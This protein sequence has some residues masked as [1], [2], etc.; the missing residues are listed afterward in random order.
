M[1]FRCDLVPQYKRYK[2]KIDKAINR[3]FLSGRYIL[4]QEVSRFEQAFARYIGVKYAAGVAN[5]TEGLI[6][7]LMAAGIGRGDEVI[8]TPFTAIPT[9][10][11]IIHSGARPVFV[12]ICSDTFLIDLNKL[13]Q[14]IT[15]KTKAIIPVHLFGNVV[16]VSKLKKLIG[17]KITVIEDASQS[18]GSKIDRLQSGSLGDLGVFSFYPTKNLGA[19]GDGGMVVSK[20]KRLIDKIKL[21]RMYGMTDK[22]HIIVHGINSRLD[23]LQAAILMVKLKYLDSMNRKR[24]IIAQRYIRKLNPALF[25]HQYIPDNVYTNYHAFASRFRGNRKRFIEYLDRNG[26]QTN[27]YYPIPLHLQKANKFLG[28]KKGSFPVAERLCKEV[29][30]LPMYPE[31]KEKTQDYIIDR[32][33]KFKEVGL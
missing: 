7:S 8:T 6:L 31:L 15:L 21:L 10:S 11:A 20:N 13:A 23:E 12:D 18:H 9:V 16:G 3:V 26:I 2:N 24:N 4:A 25:Q 1:I 33:N 32:I 28:L 29:V 14:A 17:S 27:I 22:D 5:G 19:Y 30:V